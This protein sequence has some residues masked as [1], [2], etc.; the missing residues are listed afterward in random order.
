ME[1]VYKNLSENSSYTP[2]GEIIGGAEQ[3]R[4]D[5]TEKEFK[6]FVGKELI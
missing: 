6:S 2:Y 3:T 5:Y 4:Y 1:K